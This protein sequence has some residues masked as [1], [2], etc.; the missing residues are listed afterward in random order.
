MTFKI[1]DRVSVRR[2]DKTHVKGL[3]KYVE[4][5][6]HCWVTPDDT[7]IDER[8]PDGKVWQVKLAPPPGPYKPFEL[9]AYTWNETRE[10]CRG[11]ANLIAEDD[12]AMRCRRQ[13]PAPGQRAF[14]YCIDAREELGVCGLMAR[15][16]VP[17]TVKAHQT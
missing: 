13:P 1:N 3:V 6:G 12:G 17:I 11:C 15:L 10:K 14:G 8:F 2:A 9:P 7:G 5:T 4:P 16:F